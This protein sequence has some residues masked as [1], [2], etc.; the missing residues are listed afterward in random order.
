MT[1][2]LLRRRGNRTSTMVAFVVASCVLG[3]GPL[4]TGEELRLE[5][6]EAKGEY[7]KLPAKDGGRLDV[8]STGQLHQ[9]NA[10]PASASGGGS[11]ETS[12]PTAFITARSDGY[13]VAR[14][15]GGSPL[16]GEAIVFEVESSKATMDREGTSVDEGDAKDA[17][18]DKAKSND[19]PDAAKSS[20]RKGRTQ[21]LNEKMAE[22]AAKRQLWWDDLI[23]TTRQR[24]WPELTEDEQTAAVEKVRDKAKRWQEKYPILAPYETANFVVLSNIPPA[25]VYPFIAQLDKMCDVLRV[26][27]S[28]PPDKPVFEGKAI[29]VACLQQAEF[30]IFERQELGNTNTGGAYGI[31]H[32]SSGGDVTVCC[33]RGDRPDGFAHMLVHETSHGFLHRYRTPARMPNWLNEG[34]A[35]HVADLVVPGTKI[36]ERTWDQSKAVIVRSG[37]LSGLLTRETNI[38]GNQYG[39]STRLVRFL[40][41]SNRQGFI[42]LIDMIKAGIAYPEALNRIYGVTP[43]QLAI[44]FGVAEGM[45]GLRP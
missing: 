15:V 10:S 44:A 1:E 11:A 29:V 13:L 3:Q 43:D 8:G 33:Y 9:S 32:S 5:V 25:Q 34:L 14:I 30:A 26:L 6:I 24:E 39:V 19:K 36:T 37:S 2:F 18:D 21:I 16:V 7:V 20:K 31:C 41:G 12:R 35:E 28:L 23:K 38:D 42:D 22:I 45:P 27:Y 4:M 40:I 17:G